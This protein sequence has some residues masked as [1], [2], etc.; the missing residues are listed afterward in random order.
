MK[1]L[2]HNIIFSTVFVFFTLFFS[3]FCFAQNQINTMDN[4]NNNQPKTNY[5]V[6]VI[7]A[8]EN[9]FGYEIFADGKKYIHQE[10]IPSMQGI[11]GFSTKQQAEKCG[12]N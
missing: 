4:K 3:T 10:N 6:T 1:I 5:T 9:T 11:K 8:P 7:P 2:S 12:K